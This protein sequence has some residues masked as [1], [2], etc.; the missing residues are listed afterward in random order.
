ME[1]SAFKE[2]AVVERSVRRLCM[3]RKALA[4]ASAITEMRSAVRS[5]CHESH[6]PEANRMT[7]PV[8]MMAKTD[9]NNVETATRFSMTAPDENGPLD[10]DPDHALISLFEHDLRANTFCACRGGKPVSA[11]PDHALEG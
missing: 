9:F 8:A 5:R 4:E 11:F 1:P 7:M 10:D 3:A 2:R 6:A